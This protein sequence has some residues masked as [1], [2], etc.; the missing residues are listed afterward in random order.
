MAVEG[1]KSL[2]VYK[3]S[4]YQVTVR[5][6]PFC[7]LTHLL[8]Q[9]HTHRHPYRLLKIVLHNQREKR[10]KSDKSKDIGNSN[11]VTE[12]FKIHYLLL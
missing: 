4:F 12:F 9:S 11:E 1:Q 5:P 6:P 7:S 10:L 2:K 3:T 8:N